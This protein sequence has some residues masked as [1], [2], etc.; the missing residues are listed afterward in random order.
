MKPKSTHVAFRPNMLDHTAMNIVAD[1]LAAR[2]K[3]PYVDRS[4]V[5]RLSVQTAARLA[6]EGRLFDHLDQAKPLEESDR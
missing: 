4:A 5:L 6:R 3:N 2:T 1:A